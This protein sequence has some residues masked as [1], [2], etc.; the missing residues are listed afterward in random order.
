V[1]PDRHAAVVDVLLTHIVLGTRN[2]LFVAHGGSL[3]LDAGDR[4][5]F[6]GVWRNSVIVFIG[7]LVIASRVD[8]VSDR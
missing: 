6:L 8:V 5:E 7:D 1:E 4:P 2:S 3:T